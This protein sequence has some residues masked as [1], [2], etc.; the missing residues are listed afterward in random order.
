MISFG[1]SKA[2][3]EAVKEGKLNVTFECNPGQGQESGRTDPETGIGY[4][5]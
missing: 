3:I 5:H 2:G 1:G 4:F